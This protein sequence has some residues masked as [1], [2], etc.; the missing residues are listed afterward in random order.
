MK[1]VKFLLALVFFLLNVN[2][3]LQAQ[4]KLLTNESY[5]HWSSLRYTGHWE[6]CAISNNGKYLVYNYQKDGHCRLVLKAMDGTIKREIS[7]GDGAVFTEDNERLIWLNADTMSILKL[8]TDDVQIKKGVQSFKTPERGN[9]K[10]LVYRISGEK[11]ASVLLNLH[12]GAEERFDEADEYWFDE[13]GKVLVLKTP[14]KAFWVE[15][16][17]K[18]IQISNGVPTSTFTF[19]NSFSQLA[20]IGGKSLRY[21]KPGMDSA[22]VMVD[23]ATAQKVLPNFSVT[24]QGYPSMRFNAAGDKIFFHLKKI[25]AEPSPDFMALKNK[26]NKNLWS[27]RNTIL[28]SDT[29]LADPLYCA[30]LDIPTGGVKLLTENDLRGTVIGDRYILSTTTFNYDEIYWNGEKVTLK[31]MDVSNGNATT[32]KT[33]KDAVPQMV[34]FSPDERFVIWY[35]NPTHQYYSYEIATATIRNFTAGIPYAL[36]EKENEIPA[37]RRF[38]GTAGWLDGKLLVNDQFDIWL[39]DPSGKAKPLNLTKGYGRAN[40]IMLRRPVRYEERTRPLKESNI[41]LTGFNPETKQNGFFQLNLKTGQLQMGTMGDYLYCFPAHV[42]HFIDFLSE[43][44][45][46]KARDVDLW[47]VKRSNANESAN[48]FKTS[49]FKTFEALSNIHPEKEYN[50]L[51][52]ELQKYKLPNGQVA[53]GIL[54]KPENFDPAKKYPVIFHYYEKLSDAIHTF[55]G[56]ENGEL[57]SGLSPTWG[58][59]NVPWY[60]SNGYLVFVPDLHFKTMQVERSLV[61]SMVAAAKHISTLPFVDFKRMGLQGHSFGGEGTLMTIVNTDLFA[62]AQE[63]AGLV[64]AISYYN[65]KLGAH[66]N[67]NHYFDLEQG[68]MTVT[69]WERPDV[70]IDNSPLFRLHKVK[71]PLF[72]MHN[73]GDTNVPPTQAVELFTSLRR[74]HKPVWYVNYG[75]EEG[76]QLMKFEYQMDFTLKQQQFFGH[77]L[78][79]ESKPDWMN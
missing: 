36:Y 25:N 57:S 5:R 43:D 61:E 59:I 75:A 22:K 31:V 64:N 68:N 51:T 70:Y 29:P 69:P 14:D 50:W 19:D 18:K 47:V 27:Y 39:T 34:N 11:S 6:I 15:T 23:S 7:G 1:V 4:K 53:N 79:G 33:F 30:Y 28:F 8:G 76:H 56:D 54:Y 16:G 73:E 71:T 67:R 65:H 21:F 12:T 41:L 10:W 3:L 32:I 63:T 74:L 9:G 44:Y 46:V 2:I 62:A 55:P 45:P 58:I 13:I 66:N 17:V 37:R 24:E 52:A 38:Y 78:K 35:D 77:F 60:V 42:P 72:I 48:L 40:S 26:S 20:F 49:D